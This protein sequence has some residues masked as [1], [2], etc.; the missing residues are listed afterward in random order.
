M[1][2]QCMRDKSLSILRS[3]F[4]YG[5]ILCKSIFETGDGVE[6]TVLVGM[7]LITGAISNVHN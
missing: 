3:E 4:G 2:D 6:L 5:E 7:T 1:S